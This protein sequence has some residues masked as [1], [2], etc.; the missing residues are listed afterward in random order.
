MMLIIHLLFLFFKAKI[1]SPSNIQDGNLIMLQNQLDNMKKQME[2]DKEK[3]QNLQFTNEEQNVVNIELQNKNSELLTRIKELDIE[4]DKE[5]NLAKDVEK[6]KMKIFEKEEELCRVKEELET[7]KK[8]IDNNADELKK[9]VSSLS[10]EVVDKEA[11]L[12]TLRHTLN[13]N[14]QTH[15]RLLKEANEKLATT[16]EQLNKKIEEKNKKLEQN[17]EMIDQL[18][19]GIKCL[20]AL[21]NDE[22]DDIVNNLKNELAK[23][24][25]ECKIIVDKKEQDNKIF[26]EHHISIENELRQELKSLLK[27]KN[28]EIEELQNKCTNLTSSS[29]AEKDLIE[30]L[31]LE[32][33]IAIKDLQ[34]SK[35]KNLVYSKET[36]QRV[37]DQ[38]IQPT[39]IQIEDFKD[40]FDKSLSIKDKKIA[41]CNLTLTQVKECLIASKSCLETTF[42]DKLKNKDCEIKTLSDKLNEFNNNLEQLQEV[43]KN[44]TKELEAESK[45]LQDKTALLAGLEQKYYNLECQQ[46][47]SRNELEKELTSKLKSI[48]DELESLKLEKS[49]LEDVHKSYVTEM[50]SKITEMDSKLQQSNVL[51]E[52][53]N[54][55]LKELTSAKQNELNSMNERM[56]ELEKERDQVFNHQ[57]AEL[58]A[59]DEQITELYKKIEQTLTEKQEQDLNHANLQAELTNETI[60]YQSVTND[61]QKRINELEEKLVINHESFKTKLE[62]AN[63]EKEITK[64]EN[65]N[66]I[67]KLNSL[68][69]FKSNLEEKLASNEVNKKDLQ[70]LN[71]AIKEKSNIIDD[72]QIKIKQ[73]DDL[74]VQIKNKYEAVLNKKEEEIKELLKIGQDKMNMEK[75]S[76]EE[77]TKVILDEKDKEISVLH[78][79]INDLENVKKSFKKQMEKSESQEQHLKQL[80]EIVQE[81]TKTIEENNMKIEQLNSLVSETK[82]ELETKLLK[83]DEEIQELSKIGKEKLQIEKEQIEKQAKVMLD[84]KNKENS[85]LLEKI[86]ILEKANVDLEKQLEVIETHKN[87]ITELNNS[88]EEKRKIIEDNNFNIKQ[89]NDMIV[90]SKEDFNSKLKEKE[91]N[92]NEFIKIEKGKLIEEKLN[93]EKNYQIKI[94]EKDKEMLSFVN[95]VNASEDIKI[96]FEKQLEISKLQEHNIAELKTLIEEKSKIIDENESKIKLLNN[97]IV[98]SKEEFNVKLKEKEDKIMEFMKSEEKFANGK[99]ILEENAKAVLERKDKEISSLVEKIKNLVEEKLNIKKQL[100]EL[101]C[102]QERDLIELKKTIEEKTK[103]ID[104]NNS[105]IDHLNNVMK[106]TREDFDA[107]LKEKDNEINEL[108]KMGED[109]LASEKIAF[110]TRLKTCIAEKNIEINE[111]KTELQ[112]IVNNNTEKEL[113]L[114]LESVANDLEKEKVRSSNLE[115]IKSELDKTKLEHKTELELLEVSKNNMVANMTKTIE[116]QQVLNAKLN[117]E[118]NRLKPLL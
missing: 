64:T 116:E 79:Q 14:A 109:K 103:F 53:L 26:S 41:S 2:E 40:Q 108:A 23:L 78:E 22:H 3:V 10:S 27:K 62:Q 114:K 90:L 105:K 70:N 101:S 115:K 97:T 92:I 29:S 66:L 54:K 77:K 104:D 39:F 35:T 59:K 83:K 12:N 112:E 85:T 36:L 91:E 117:E 11:V 67:E 99:L 21:K 63:N 96:S 28:Q 84:E 48:N 106:Q 32:L 73:L 65:L 5:R 61:L 44:L 7:L 71:D 24:K 1:D 110:E 6:E 9:S 30:K 55:L 8:L 17:Q 15:D 107:K 68:E 87:T 88:I 52:N 38:Q 94:D 45:S 75:L 86:N 72:N 42:N 100:L 82:N 34:V 37:L 58:A 76:L 51:I 43:N 74:I 20:S 95:K 113:I 18:N 102:T 89:L 98:S 81:K 46:D 118:L 69:H 57:K 33:N 16:T 60:K 80:N 31:K 111:L 56:S 25:D 93:L 13:E 4:L 47:L 50:S 19:E 49:T